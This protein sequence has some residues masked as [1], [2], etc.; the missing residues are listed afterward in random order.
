[1]HLIATNVFL[2]LCILFPSIISIFSLLNLQSMNRT[3]SNSV[4]LGIRT[5]SILGG[6]GHSGQIRW[7]VKKREGKVG[8]REKRTKNEF[9]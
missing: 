8:E 2:F 3:A 4:S 9:L 7:C 6:K 1:M 5:Y